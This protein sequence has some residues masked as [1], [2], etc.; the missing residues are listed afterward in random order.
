MFD[1]FLLDHFIGERF[2]GEFSVDLTAT[3][4]AQDFP[5]LELRLPFQILLDEV[6]VFLL[7]QYS[8]LIEISKIPAEPYFENVMVK[9]LLP[10]NVFG[11]PQ[12]R[13]LRMIDN[14]V[15]KIVFEIK[16]LLIREKQIDLFDGDRPQFVRR[17]NIGLIQG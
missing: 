2:V 8:F 16:F 15:D 3:S 11:Q 9:A 17:N 12:F 6:A 7:T 14:V 5:S 1:R 4:D 10:Y 13:F